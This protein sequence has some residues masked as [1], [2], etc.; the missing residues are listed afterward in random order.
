MKIKLTNTTLLLLFTFQ[1]FSQE[2]AV[3]I[4]GIIY[5]FNEM[6]SNVHIINLNTGIGTISDDDGNF[7]I[8]VRLNDK[9]LISSIQYE[10]QYIKI[11]E[12]ILSSKEIS[13]H[14]I[15]SVTIL[16][17]VMIHGLS[18]DLTV[19]LAKI[20]EDKTPKMNFKF[21]KNDLYKIPLYNNTFSSN[22]PPSVE[23][24]VNP[25]TLNGAGAGA[26]FNNYAY[27][28]EMKLKKNLK[29]KKEIPVK[30]IGTLGERFFTETLHISKD[31][32]H[33]FLTYC[34]TR[35]IIEKFNKNELLE[36]IEILQEESIAY[37][38]LT[39]NE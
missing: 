3:E 32:I 26:T 38:K 17:E 23:H 9:L 29:L 37:H 24:M 33:H 1:C 11:T 22:K 15:P 36:L 5:G 27:I 39:K 7:E 10:R 34:E 28:A 13:I 12:K 30:I 16:D 14:L 19:D 21:D 18:G 35:N 4:K 20:P 31:S 2:N 8:E 6:V 25:I